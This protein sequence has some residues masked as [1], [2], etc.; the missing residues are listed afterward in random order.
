[1]AFGAALGVCCWWNMHGY[2]PCMVERVSPVAAHNQTGKGVCELASLC[3]TGMMLYMSRRVPN[4]YCRK[5]QVWLADLRGAVGSEQSGVR[6][7]L[8]LKVY[9]KEMILVVPLTSKNK[10]GTWY[11]PI[12]F[13]SNTKQQQSFVMLSHVRSIHCNRLL[14]PIGTVT[15][16][17]FV[18]LLTATVQ[19]MH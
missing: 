12:E 3:M 18:G 14:R 9:S 6:P 17:H 4:R 2:W 11:M 5:R 16:Q 8:V 15:K 7:V 19:M 1:M 10:G 13:G